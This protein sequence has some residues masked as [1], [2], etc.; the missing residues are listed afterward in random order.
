MANYPQ[1]ILLDNNGVILELVD[2]TPINTFST[3]GISF[4]YIRQLGASAYAGTVD[5]YVQYKTE[6][7]LQ[8]IQNGITYVYVLAENIL[9]RQSVIEVP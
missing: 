8:F 4:G 1:G 7:A 5:D 3:L 6:G 9:F 2:E